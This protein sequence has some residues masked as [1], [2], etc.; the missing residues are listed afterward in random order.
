MSAEQSGMPDHNPLEDIARAIELAERARE[1]LL[2]DA[3]LNAWPPTQIEEIGSLADRLGGL[4]KDVGEIAMPALS[5]IEAAELDAKI[6]DFFTRNTRNDVSIK[7][8]SRFVGNGNEL[9]RRTFKALRDRVK[10]RPGIRYRVFTH[11]EVSDPEL[12]RR[13]TGAEARAEDPQA[14]AVETS[15]PEPPV[16][17]VTEPVERPQKPRSVPTPLMI[18]RRLQ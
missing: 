12:V 4:A 3:A 2:R 18:A 8:I 16:L 6:D 1:G 7:D 11:V 10:A 17:R 9:P 14:Q 13:P 5:P 15:K